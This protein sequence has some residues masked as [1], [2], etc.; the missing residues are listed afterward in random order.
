M[1]EHRGRL[2]ATNALNRLSEFKM[3]K[4]KKDNLDDEFI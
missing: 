4:K 3:K 1:N 2:E